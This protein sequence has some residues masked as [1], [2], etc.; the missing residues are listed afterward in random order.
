MF[1]GSIEDEGLKKIEEY[2]KIMDASNPDWRT[3][4]GQKKDAYSPEDKEEAKT[5]IEELN[6]KIVL[7]E[8]AIKQAKDS[9]E[10]KELK[11]NLDETLAERK[12]W[13]RVAIENDEWAPNSVSVVKKDFSDDKLYTIPVNTLYKSAK[14]ID[15]VDVLKFRAIRDEQ[16]I[17][18]LEAKVRWLAESKKEVEDTFLEHKKWF[19]DNR[20]SIWIT[21]KWFIKAICG[22]IKFWE[23]DL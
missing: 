6:S 20:K 1:M 3:T 2:E 17:K 11:Y 4:K 14:D 19:L 9:D 10:E 21:F 23:N 16:Y 18:G 22:K 8:D 7:I 15:N 13:E 5:K 12:Y